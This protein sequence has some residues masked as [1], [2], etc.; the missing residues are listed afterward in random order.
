VLPCFFTTTQQ[1]VPVW[2]LGTFGLVVLPLVPF[3]FP[4]PLQV[5]KFRM[6]ARI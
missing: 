4:S 3:P 6:K 2:R 1:S 5:L